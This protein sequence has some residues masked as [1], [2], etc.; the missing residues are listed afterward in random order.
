MKNYDITDSFLCEKT[1][2]NENLLDENK[3]QKILDDRQHTIK[4]LEDKIQIREDE[5][6]E[7]NG[8][9]KPCFQVSAR[10]A[11][12]HAREGGTA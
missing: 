8:G 11:G 12:D 1:K 4:D 6:R 10:I 5:K 3:M 7:Y 9:Q 2:F